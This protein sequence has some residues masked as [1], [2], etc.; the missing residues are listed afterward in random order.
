MVTEKPEYGATCIIEVK[1][2]FNLLIE[3]LPSECK[4]IMVAVY[5]L[6]SQGVQNES[7]GANKANVTRHQP[8]SRCFVAAKAWNEHAVMKVQMKVLAESPVDISSPVLAEP[9]ATLGVMKISSSLLQ[10]RR[11]D[12]GDAMKINP[13][14]E[15]MYSF[16]TTTGQTLSIEQLFVSNLSVTV[17]NA[18]LK[19]LELERRSECVRFRNNISHEE[20][21][22]IRDINQLRSTP[23]VIETVSELILTNSQKKLKSSADLIEEIELEFLEDIDIVQKHCECALSGKKL[24]QYY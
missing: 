2:Q 15:M 5:K 21:Q 16:G 17:P 9:T 18:L 12:F 8:L 20:F 6:E 11:K 24:F 10:R 1:I 14:C 23:D 7:S 22:I 3:P 4:Q 13:Y 19:L